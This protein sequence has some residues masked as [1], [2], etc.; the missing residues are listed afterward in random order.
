VKAGLFPLHVWL[1]EA[2]AAAPSHV[3][4]MMSG[5]SIEIGLYGLLRALSFLPPAPWWGPALIVIGFAGAAFAIS[6]ALAQRDLKRALAYS[7]IE[8]MGLI[9]IGLG[10]A[11]WGAAMG[12]PAVA[13]LGALAAGFHLWSHALMKGLLFLCAGSVLHGAGT[14]DLEALGGLARRMKW[15]GPLL[16]LGAVAIAGLPPLNGFVAEWLLLRGLFAG[17]LARAGAPGIAA[18]LAVGAL[19]FVGALAA[20]CFVRLAGIAL[21]G[22]PRSEA[23]A[24]AHESPAGML[25]PMLLL[26]GGCVALSLRPALAL[27]PVAAFAG[28]IFG[29]Q[30][31][32][33][34]EAL[35][36][37]LASLGAFSSATVL[38]LAALAA[39]LAARVRRP[40]AALTWDCG[41]AA[42]TAR[43]QYTAG[44]FAQL[45]T[46]DLLPPGLVPRASVQLPP[47]LFPAPAA[48]RTEDAD[49]LLR[50]WYEPFVARWAD[51]F[52]GLH[53]LQ[54][55]VLHVYLF[56]I[57]AVAVAGLAWASLRGWIGR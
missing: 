23:A 11:F 52:A 29:A 4:A 18:L 15:T 47:G 38:L 24:H 12:A 1:P 28:Q 6:Q 35:A 39:V 26:A 10:I 32:A 49:P 9:L 17:A 53:W 40:A 46:E 14:R 8:N 37:S 33:A 2:H 22:N 21:L 19:A 43:M 55:G 34:V 36:P 44:S 54:Q 45:A 5:A 56:Y 41:Y 27:R 7:S 57:L 50:R 3:S 13:A 20:L 30:V 16:L 51:R 31:A 48:W 25:A 42:P